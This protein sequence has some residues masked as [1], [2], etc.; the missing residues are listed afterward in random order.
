M[1]WTANGMVSF[2]Y[3]VDWDLGKLKKKG[4]IQILKMAWN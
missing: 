2:N 1:D 4:L 3:C